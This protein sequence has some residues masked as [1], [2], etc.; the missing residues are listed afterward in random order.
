MILGGSLYQSAIFKDILSIGYEFESHDITKLSLHENKKWLINS[1][2]TLRTLKDRKS[3]KTITE[4]ANSKYLKTRIPIHKNGRTKQ[5][6][7]DEY[8]KKN[9]AVPTEGVTEPVVKQE[10]EEE[11]EDEGEDEGEDEEAKALREYFEIYAHEIADEKQEE[12]NMEKLKLWENES[13]LEYFSENRKTDFRS[14]INGTQLVA[15]NVTNDQ[16]EID[17]DALLK[18][19]CAELGIHKNDMY[20]FRAKTK[21]QGVFEDYK[22]K[23]SEDIAKDCESLSGVEY[24][25]TYFEPQNPRKP[26]AN[27]IVETYIDACSRIL[28]HLGDLE[29]VSGQ[30]VIDTTT[31]KNT[32][33]YQPIGFLDEIM[34]RKLYHKKNT[35]LYY[36]DTYDDINT[37][38]LINFDDI[39]FIP[40]MTFR[41]KTE[42][43]IEIMKHMLNPEQKELI[44]LVSDKVHIEYSEEVDGFLKE[45]LETIQIIEGIVDGLITEFN[46]THENIINI[47]T[48]IG[49]RFKTY[50]FFIFFKLYNFIINHSSILSGKDYLKDQLSFAS[51]HGNYDFYLIVK[52]M[53][54]EQY[55]V[56]DIA[57]IQ[58]FFYQPAILNVIYDKVN[59]R[60]AVPD[61]DY[62]EEGDY[63]Y[64]GAFVNNNEITDKNDPNYGNPIYS[65]SSYFKYFEDPIDDIDSDI[66]PERDWLIY[67][68][69]DT[70]TTTFE[71]KNDEIL[72]ENRLFRNE[73][74]YVIN[75]LT[76]SEY[77]EGII[78]IGG[79]RD[80][81]KKIDKIYNLG[82][83]KKMMFAKEPFKAQF[84][85]KN[86]GSRTK[87][88]NNKLRV[89]RKKTKTSQRK[90][91]KH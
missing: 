41:C 19:K 33:H 45:D 43:A 52:K 5:Q 77:S 29:V 89:T 3:T 55:K 53:F 28:D 23:F 67:S 85:K 70:Y 75:M 69:K 16:G 88:V 34:K 56:T 9:G 46:K 57:E 49:K 62:T 6:I 24:I 51:R 26:N 60:E 59:N 83:K 50:V 65:I 63:I 87:K 71:L 48:V 31:D 90:T 17:L 44:S 58:G 81:V 35:N 18:E 54:A 91:K 30:L 84:T 38:S 82:I 39:E 64:E 76:G 13:Y 8:D 22:L 7:Y 37:Q 14:D 2:L 11:D 21:T 47:V 36:M 1:D 80:I 66:K 86:G 42:N 61:E 10:E 32:G 79:M 15:F 78:T 12:H 68:K 74:E 40:Q 27:I 4:Q 72:L 25:I 20:I 73:I